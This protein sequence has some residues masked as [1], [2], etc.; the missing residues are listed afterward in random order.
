M[1]IIS[2]QE[3]FRKDTEVRPGISIISIFFLTRVLPQPKNR[4]TDLPARLHRWTKSCGQAVLPARN[5]SRSDPP[6]L[7]G[8]ALRA[9]VGRQ[10]CRRVDTDTESFRLKRIRL[11]GNSAFLI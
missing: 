3:S 9:G 7:L 11:G 6:A 5:T 1:V 4:T 8:E 10:R 2:E